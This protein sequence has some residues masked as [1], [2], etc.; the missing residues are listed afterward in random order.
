MK[1]DQPCLQAERELE[2]W[3]IGKRKKKGNPRKAERGDEKKMK[4]FG[5][6]SVKKERNR[7]KKRRQSASEGTR[8]DGERMKRMRKCEGENVRN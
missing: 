4:R 6:E 7:R 1:S 5:G 8:R 2:E 3:H